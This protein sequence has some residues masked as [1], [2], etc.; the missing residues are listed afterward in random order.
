M[1]KNMEKSWGSVENHGRIMGKLI[2]RYIYRGLKQEKTH[3]NPLSPRALPAK[4]QRQRRQGERRGT[5]HAQQP[6][7]VWQA[8]P[9]DRK[10]HSCGM[11]A[12]NIP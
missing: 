6:G 3:R 9:G 10:C 2:I 8:L 11:L 12:M 7:S 1:E 5:Q 4:Q